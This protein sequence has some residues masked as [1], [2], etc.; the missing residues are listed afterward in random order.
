MSRQLELER[1]PRGA[2]ALLSTSL[3]TPQAFGTRVGVVRRWLADAQRLAGDAGAAHASYEAARVDLEAQLAL[4]PSNP[5]FLGELA[6][7]WARLGDR[8][9]AG[10]LAQ[11]CT[12]LARASRRSSYIGDC[13]LA[14][15]QVAL[16]ANDT[17]QLPGLLEDALK[18]RGSLPPLTVSLLRL[19]PELDAQRALVRTL[20]PD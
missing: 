10:E 3:A 13:G 2:A 12:Q 5:L 15:I 4:Q 18:Q 19:D 6:I 9:A 8:A 11:R 14:R 1:D 7:V 17:A 16:A 20:T